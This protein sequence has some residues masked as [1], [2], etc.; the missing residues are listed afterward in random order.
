MPPELAELLRDN[1]QARRACQAALQAAFQAGQD[2][3][4]AKGYGEGRAVT[5]ALAHRSGCNLNHPAGE[6]C[7]VPSDVG[8]PPLLRAADGTDG[9]RSTSGGQIVTP[10]TEEPR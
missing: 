1:E 3:G 5:A 6:P 10:R 7:E 4:W 8:L 2:V 9:F